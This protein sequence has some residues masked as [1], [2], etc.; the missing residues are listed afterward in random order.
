MN[1][2]KD[3]E[4]DFHSTVGQKTSDA[5][6]F[7]TIECA[8]ALALSILTVS[9]VDIEKLG[10][11]VSMEEPG[12][13]DLNEEVL[14][15]EDKVLQAWTKFKNYVKFADHELVKPISGFQSVLEEDIKSIDFQQTYQ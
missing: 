15:S 10:L 12:S 14:S 9:N 4:Q 6:T 5:S 3:M 13:F 2:I 1:K 8:T 7:S 11:K